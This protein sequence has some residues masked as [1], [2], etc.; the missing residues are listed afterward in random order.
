[1]HSISTTFSD[2]IMWRGA[3]ETAEFC[4]FG[5]FSVVLHVTGMGGIT[6]EF[7]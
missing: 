6:A 3:K 5:R 4:R 1:M 7:L 2:C